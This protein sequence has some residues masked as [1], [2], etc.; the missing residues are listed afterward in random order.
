MKKADVK[1][2]LIVGVICGL[3]LVVRYFGMDTGASVVVEVNGE[4]YG[5][6]SLSKDQT[7]QINDTNV[8]VIEDGEAYMTEASCPDGLCISQ[9]HISAEGTMIVCLPNRV[10]VQVIDADADA[11]EGLDAVTG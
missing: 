11:E 1:L 6:Y 8:L 10:V 9:G 4:T 3:L 5:T 2:I 7:I